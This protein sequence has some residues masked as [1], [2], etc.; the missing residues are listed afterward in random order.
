METDVTTIGTIAAAFT[1]ILGAVF[2]GFLKLLREIRR[3]L[4]HSSEQRSIL[5]AER[6]GEIQGELKA[7]GKNADK[8]TKLLEDIVHKI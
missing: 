7:I 5:A 2:G 1:L 6:H 3:I 8:Q 4:N